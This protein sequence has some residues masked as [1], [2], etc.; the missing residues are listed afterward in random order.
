MTIITVCG[1]GFGTSLMLKMTIDDILAENKIKAEVSA[2]DLGSVKGRKAD[3]FVA[4]EDMKS[5]L[6]DIG[7]NI[8]FIKNLTDTN[9]VREKILKAVKQFQ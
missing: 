5:N 7:S 8:I 1:M 3:L 2:W 6:T 4:S 9:E